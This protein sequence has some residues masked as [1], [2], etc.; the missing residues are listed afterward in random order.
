MT[1]NRRIIFTT[2][3]ALAVSGI[4]SGIRWNEEVGNTIKSATD[5]IVES[6]THIPLVVEAPEIAPNSA[7]SASSTDIVSAK[8]YLVGDIITGKI[9]LEKNS[10]T[11]LPIASISKLITTLSVGTILSSTTR[12][13]I[14]PEEAALPPDGSLISAGETFT[15][16]EILYPL[17]LDSSNIAAEALASS[18]NRTDFLQTM[19]G[20]S[21]EI[22]MNSTSFT[23]PSGLSSSDVSTAKDIFTLARY[24]YKYKPDILNIT[25]TPVMSLSTTTDHGSHTFLSTHPFIGDPRFLGGKT[26]RTLA[27]GETMLTILDMGGENGIS[28]KPT[29]FIVLGS[30]IGAREKDTLLLIDKAAGII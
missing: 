16:G 15:V 14:T 5:V 25:R 23:D 7:E 13:S 6:G 29:V 3:S 11:I 18:S 30:N 12:I 9:Y 17:L 21:H 24:L 27:A 8:A 19:S 22:G 20:Y 2:V 10:S 28:S 4:F 1:I 26:G